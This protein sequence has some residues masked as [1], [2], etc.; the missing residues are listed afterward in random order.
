MHA[1]TLTSKMLG[2]KF[3]SFLRFPGGFQ[4]SSRTQRRGLVDA[5]WWWTG[6]RGV[7]ATIAKH[8]CSAVD[9]DCVC[10]RCCDRGQQLDHLHIGE[11][12]QNPQNATMEC[13]LQLACSAKDRSGGHRCCLSWQRKAV[14][15]NAN[16]RPTAFRA[17]CAVLGV[18][19]N[20]YCSWLSFA[21]PS[22]GFKCL[23]LGRKPTPTVTYMHACMNSIKSAVLTSRPPRCILAECPCPPHTHTAPAWRWTTLAFA[24]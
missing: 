2:G 19:Q 21:L 12:A 3:V 24:L 15:T 18:P 5:L 8:A 11:T 1:S 17:L 6:W 7:R 20:A 23:L 13:L 22:F 14:T 9:A 10:E 4:V 16:S